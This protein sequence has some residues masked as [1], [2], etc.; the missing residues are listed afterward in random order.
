MP[1]LPK[2]R[3]SAGFSAEDIAA[4]KL[5]AAGHDVLQLRRNTHGIDMMV[6]GEPVEVKAAIHTEYK[7][8]DG[9]PIRGYV[10]SNMKKEP[11]ASK[12]IFMCM[13]DDRSKVLKEYHI[14]AEK[15]KQRTLTI[16]RNGKYEGFR[17]DA[18]QIAPYRK[19]DPYPLVQYDLDLEN[20]KGHNDERVG[21][22][23]VVKGALIGAGLVAAA[24]AF[25]EIQKGKVEHTIP[26]EFDKLLIGA[27]LGAAISTRI[28]RKK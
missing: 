26:V 18:A 22:K 5:R 23:Q 10:F 17:K 11:K 20:R 28:G 21:V 14:P 6:D 13:S 4:Q 8:S 9:Y 19:Y 24:A 15:V 3:P 12:Y 7:G 2:D 27:A 25:N 16:T 1:L